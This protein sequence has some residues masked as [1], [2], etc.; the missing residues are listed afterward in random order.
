MVR[1]LY[2]IKSSGAAFRVFLAEQLDDMGFKSSNT[3]PEVWMR[4]STKSDGED[5]YAHCGP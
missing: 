4:E 1:A 2:V 3:E 5:Y